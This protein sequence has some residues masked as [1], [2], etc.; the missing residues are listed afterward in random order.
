MCLVSGGTVV[1][2][3]ALWPHSKKVPGSNS[4]LCGVCM[5]STYLCG[6]LTPSKTRQALQLVP[7]HVTIKYLSNYSDF[8]HPIHQTRVNSKEKLFGIVR[9]FSKSFIGANHILSSAAHATNACSLQ[10]WHHFKRDI[11]RH[12]N[13]IRC[14]AKKHCY[15]K[16]YRKR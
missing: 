6:F 8:N 2:W 12:S 7:L 10:M 9:R 4:F 14:I 15:N 16:W 1:Q 13:G 5:F 3:I 11:N